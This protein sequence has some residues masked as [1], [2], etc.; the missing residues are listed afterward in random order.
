MDWI[1][2]I[3]II[4]TNITLIAAML[5]I[6]LGMYMFLDKKI[7]ENRKETSDILRA[8]QEEIKDFHGKFCQMERK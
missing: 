3:A 2:A 1:Q 7:D 5:G 6:I 4:G 8:I